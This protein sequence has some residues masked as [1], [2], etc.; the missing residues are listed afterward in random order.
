LQ[1]QRIEYETGERAEYMPRSVETFAVL[2]LDRTLLESGVLVDLMCMQL[3]N[4][5]VSIEQVQKDIDFVRRNNG[6]SFS[7]LDFLEAQYGQEKYMSIMQEIEEQV[8]NGELTSELLCEGTQELLAALD[9]HDVPYAVLTYGERLNQEFK[10]TLLRHMVNRGTKQIHATVT[11][12]SKK[13]T[14]IAGIEWKADGK[15]GFAV[16]AFVYPQADLHAKHIVVIDDKLANLE[17]DDD[18]VRG[19]LVDNTKGSSALTTADVARMLAE[20]TDLL[21]IAEASSALIHGN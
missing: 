6:Q 5:G 12:E 18:A 11:S 8:K 9:A 4:H 10:V 16:P 2:D 1:R 13:A 15:E 17:S 19:I 20:G 3:L 21:A 14:W 7:M